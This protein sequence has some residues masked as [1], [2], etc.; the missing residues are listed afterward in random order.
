MFN[1][2]YICALDIGSSKIA[3]C[4]ARIKRG[5]INNIS[6]DSLPAKGIKEGIIVDSIDLVSSVTKLLKN[7]K[8]KS[9]INIKFLYS[10]ISG[11]NIITKHSHATV[12]LA[13]RGNKIIT[14]LDL[15]K[16]NEQARILGLNLEEEI[17]QKIPFGYT[18]D[19]SSN[20]LN[21]LGLYSHKLGV[22]LYLICAKLSSLQSLSRLINQSGYQIKGLFFSGLATSRAVFNKEL[23]EGFNLVCDIGCDIAELLLFKNGLLCDIEILSLGGNDLTLQIQNALQV[24]FDLAEDIKKSYGII[25]DPMEIEEDREI[26]VKK[27][28][29]YKTIK[30]RFVTEVI[31]SKAKS[32]CSIIKDTI[33]KKVQPYK[34]NNFIVTG[35][36]VLLEGFIETLES[37]LEIPV[38][39]GRIMN[40]EILSVTKED[41][42]LLGQKY[43]TYLTA[44]GIIC[45]AQEE[46]MPQILPTHKPAKNFISKAINR[47]KEIYQEYF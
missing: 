15:E 20:I 2:N 4:V 13:E 21:P 23:K 46:S 40:P 7:L 30:Q 1:N 36:S 19:T 5:R 18:I 3:A 28:S 41:S 17:I 47:F 32:I 45:Q 35:R 8:N 10:N 38:K 16:V 24:P 37:L 11:K 26:L 43:L 39:L 33:E 34:V 12:P 25:G 42:A 31:N 6:F 29:I 14:V 44:L 9:G 22:D 27:G